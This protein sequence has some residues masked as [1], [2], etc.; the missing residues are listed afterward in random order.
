MIRSWNQSNFTKIYFSI[1][2]ERIKHI[3][4]MF[5][6]LVE[7]ILLCNDK[8]IEASIYQESVHGVLNITNAT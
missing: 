7:K 1:K 8:K 5:S 2:K 3:N 6:F 4:S